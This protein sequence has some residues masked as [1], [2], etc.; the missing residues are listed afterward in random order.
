MP[1]IEIYLASALWNGRTATKEEVDTLPVDVFEAAVT[2]ALKDFPT[3]ATPEAPPPRVSASEKLDSAN[4]ELANRYAAQETQRR[5]TQLAPAAKREKLASLPASYRL[6]I[7]NDPALRKR[8]LG[9][10]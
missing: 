3:W 5:A 8:V 2:R 4:V 10:N 9:E 1:T 7:A 6:A